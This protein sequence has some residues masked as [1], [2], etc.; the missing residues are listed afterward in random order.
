[1]AHPPYIS[2]LM[3]VYNTPLPLVKRAI[4]SVLQQTYQDFELW[5][6]D[7]GSRADISEAVRQYCER[8]SDKIRYVRHDNRGQAPTINRGVALS[9]SP[10]V[11]II[12]SDD[13]YKPLH[14]QLCMAKMADFDLIASYSHTIVDADEDYYIPDQHDP[15]K[16]IH[17]DDC[18]LFATLFGKR[19]VFEQIPFAP[20]YG[21]DADFFIR[22]AKDFCV[23]KVDLR[24]YV[25][26][27]N[28]ANSI[29]STL[30][31]EQQALYQ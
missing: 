26:Y 7:D 31:K 21:S 10:Y 8:K 22:A 1:M 30:K 2:V 5:V 19:T 14:L 29:C 18:I 6:L 16:N 13:E 20:Q 23:Q 15:R 27:R 4:Q 11:T 17:V 12:D 28:V 24:T 3:T 9:K 25:Y